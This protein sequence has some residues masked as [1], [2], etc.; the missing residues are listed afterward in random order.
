MLVLFYLAAFVASLNEVVI[1][2]ALVDIM[3]AFDVS[4]V[5][6]QWL[7][8]G[9]M[10]VTVV[11]VASIAYLSRRFS[12]RALFLVG[13]SCFIVGSVLAM[14]APGF[15]FLLCSRLVQAVGSGVFIPLMMSVVM[16][17]A[18][19]DKLGTYFS[20]GSCCIVLGPAFG[21]VIS[22]IMVTL[23]G[24]RG[25]FLPGCIAFVAVLLCGLRMVSDFAEPIHL[26]LDGISIP[27][28]VIG[29]VALSF[30]LTQVAS[31][32][33][34]A[35]VS[36][37]VGIVFLALFG[38]RQLRLDEPV[39]NVRLLARPAF[40]VACIM[41][42]VAMMT[43]F[44][45]SVLLPM[46]LEEALGQS[47]FASGILMLVPISVNAVTA[48]FSGRILDRHGVFPLLPAGFAVVVVGL[49]L[50]HAAGALTGDGSVACLMA[51]SAVAYT[52]VGLVFAPSQTAGLSTLEKEENADGIALVNVCIQLAGCVGP[53]LF[54]G[55]LSSGAA[56]AQ[57]AGAAAS[58]ALAIGF[59]DALF[60]A[61]CVAAVGFVLSCV[62]VG[63]MR[64]RERELSS[65]SR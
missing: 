62:L 45:L 52:G 42:I 1:N 23:T 55:I 7:V 56:N 26:K 36:L 25:V 64:R 27:L 8:T 43:T 24:W 31:D 61:C 50:V 44:S 40:T 63:L 59:Q 47:A 34:V 18:P 6:A 28:M 14:A 29:L 13:A 12:L 65:E 17:V 11:I 48:L 4:S 3:D 20:I 57:A 5:T 15:E 49:I 54:V 32:A 9:Y 58:R 10:I 37:A 2:V 22:G 16:A 21:P 41:V 33:P 60:V 30:G 39:L 38:R 19:R 51:A 53:A 35:L 46:H